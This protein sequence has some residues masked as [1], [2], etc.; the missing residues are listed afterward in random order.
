M[1][2]FELPEIIE[3]S[4]FNGNFDLYIEAIYQVFKNDFIDSKP[5]F[6]GKR[7][8]L[9]RLPVVDGRECTFYHLTHEGDIET[10]RIPNLRRMECIPWPKPIINN[11]F[12]TCLK[13]WKNTRRGKGGT[14]TRILIFHEQEKYLLILDERIDF[15][16]P[17][18]A[19][20]VGNSKKESLLK[21]Y[22]NYLKAETANGD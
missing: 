13:V 2:D 15:V 11:S 6:R 17:W 14:K 21:E 8:G 16:L 12:S 7:V 10:Q 1:V 19:Y 5:V 22:E 3:L 9:K 20:C 4:E 18:T